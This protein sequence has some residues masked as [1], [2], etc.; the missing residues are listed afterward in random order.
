MTERSSSMSQPSSMT[1]PRAAISAVAGSESLIQTWAIA[2]AMS[3]PSTTAAVG[4]TR[5]RKRCMARQSFWALK[6]N[7]GAAAHGQEAA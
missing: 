4:L 6:T 3:L 7:L 5:N 2:P 1:T